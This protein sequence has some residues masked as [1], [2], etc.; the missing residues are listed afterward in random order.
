M[1]ET[2][3]KLLDLGYY[4]LKFAFVGLEDENVWKRPA[5]ELLSVGELAGHLA[6]WEA[7]RLAG[8]GDDLS[9]CLIR[10]PLIAQQFRYHTTTLA[11][12]PSEQHPMM[13]AK[14]VCNEL[15][16]VHKEAVAHFKEVNP[17]PATRI[18]GCPTGFN[19]GEYLE[20][21]VFHIAYH[22]GQMYSVR[23]LLGEETPDN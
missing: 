15:L 2:C 22:T 8:E 9:K 10:S 19:Y 4:E 5:P 13:T 7:V 17:D 11:T 21:A 23:H 20:Y 14:Q 16:R 6:Y 18:P 1:F 12:T 3:L